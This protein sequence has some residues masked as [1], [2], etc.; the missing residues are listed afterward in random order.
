VQLLPD[1]FARWT[2]IQNRRGD[3]YKFFAAIADA[4]TMFV[5]DGI[6]QLKLENNPATAGWRL[7][8]YEAALGLSTTQTALT[9][10]P[11]ARRAQIIS[12][13]R[14][15]GAS[16]I[17]NI[18]SILGPL[19]GY[20][21]PTQLQVFECN[22]AALTAAHTYMNGSGAVFISP[23]TQTVYVADDG[24]VSDAGAQLFI[25]VTATSVADLQLTLT[26]PASGVGAGIASKVWPA[27]SIPGGNVSG[28]QFR[29][30]FPEAAGHKLLGEWALTMSSAASAVQVISW[31]LFVEGGGLRDAQGGSGLGEEMHEWGVFVDPVLALAQNIPAVK[32][33]M[34]RIQPA[35]SVADLLYSVAGAYPDVSSGINSALPDCC[36]PA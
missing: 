16:T 9:G 28:A 23:T 15:Q 5:Y 4:L 31:S 6:A 33:A 19:L 8:D 21:D 20:V 30:N 11:T 34:T 18:Q 32:A 10:T 13:L 7:P 35:D 1:G 12:K 29:L 25:T 14:E 2:G 27:G 36:L 17:F 24:S 26:G 3:V 22:R